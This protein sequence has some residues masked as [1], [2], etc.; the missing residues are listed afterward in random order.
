MKSNQIDIVLYNPSIENGG[1]EKNLII[2]SKLLKPYFENLY[3]ISESRNKKH[4]FDKSLKFL[5]FSRKKIKFKNRLIHYFYSFFVLISFFLKNRKRNIVVISFQ[6]NVISTLISKI[7]NNKII[8]RLNTSPQKYITNSIKKYFYKLI[9]KL[10]DQIIVNCKEFKKQT[11]FIFG[12]DSIVIFNFIEKVKI[13]KIKKRSNSLKLINIGRLTEQKDHLTLLKA[14]KIIQKEIDYNLTIIGDG[15]LYNDIK[16]YINF[17]NLKKIK[18][19]KKTNNP[20][21]QIL[22]SDLFVLTSKFEGMPNVLIEAL[23][24]KTYIIST[25]CPTGPD[26]LLNK[27]KFGTLIKVGDYVELSKKI[28]EFSKKKSS[29]NKK[30]NY[31]FKS[32]HRFDNNKNL[33][34]LL[35][36]IYNL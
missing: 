7:F 5:S 14:I 20:Y 6:S 18:L 4:L 13:K 36:I 15:H 19:I 10:S 12:L 35:K 22:K 25:N 26:E 3:L 8:I 33:N 30:I 11:N 21:K 34:K 23:Q 32:L 31:G 2:I 29:Y 17:N 16:D 28:I 24:C 9:Y 27:G 1:V